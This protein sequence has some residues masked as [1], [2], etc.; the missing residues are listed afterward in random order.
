MAAVLFQGL[1]IRGYSFSA[2]SLQCRCVNPACVVLFLLFSDR[3]LTPDRQLTVLGKALSLVESKYQEETF[4]LIELLTTGHLQP[5][6]LHTQPR[7][8]LLGTHACLSLLS[9]V[10]WANSDTAV[11]P[12]RGQLPLRQGDHAHFACCELALHELPRGK[13]PLVLYILVRAMAI[14][15]LFDRR[16][17]RRTSRGRVPSTTS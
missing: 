1:E 13:L 9:A 12:N 8:P 17:C 2:G 14:A 11:C 7:R 3:Y 16:W 5:T 15:H 6:P 10:F 4:I